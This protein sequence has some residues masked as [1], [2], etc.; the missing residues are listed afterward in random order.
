MSNDVVLEAE[1][2]ARIFKDNIERAIRQLSPGYIVDLQGNF[3][4]WPSASQ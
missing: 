3:K 4:D 1:R 2:V